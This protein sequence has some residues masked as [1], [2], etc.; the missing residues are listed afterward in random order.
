MTT[1]TKEQIRHVANFIYM[2]SHPYSRN[3][4]ISDKLPMSA[5]DRRFLLYA[6]E[7][8]KEWEI[9]RNAD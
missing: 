2:K 9:I 5:T 7:A 3:V 8:I 1:P 4:I 6:E